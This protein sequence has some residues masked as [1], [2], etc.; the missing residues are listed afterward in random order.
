MGGLAEAQLQSAIEALV[1]RDADLAA[2]V[3]QSD[4]DQN[5]R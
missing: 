2:Q 3:V 1:R 5:P 4:G